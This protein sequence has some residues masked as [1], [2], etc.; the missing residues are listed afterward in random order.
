MSSEKK[1]GNEDEDEEEIYT[2]EQLQDYISLGISGYIR[3]NAN[4]LTAKTLIE[5][6]VEQMLRFSEK[7]ITKEQIL[8]EIEP[9][10][11]SLTQQFYEQLKQKVLGKK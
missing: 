11:F 4:N 2:I 10:N 3:D 9:L 1:N 8:E 5:D 7:Q 6:C